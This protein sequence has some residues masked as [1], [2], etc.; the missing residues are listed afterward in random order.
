MLKKKGFT[1]IELLVVISIIAL[2]LSILMPA[3]NAV[4]ERTRFV[5][6]K[7]N[8]RQLSVAASAYAGDNNDKL[9]HP[10]YFLHS[11]DSYQ[12][13]YDS[14]TPL[15]CIWHDDNL[16]MDSVLWAYL[17][18]RDVVRCPTFAVVCNREIHPNHDPSIPIKPKFGYVM[19][20]YVLKRWPIDVPAGLDPTL[21]EGWFTYKLSEINR[22][23]EVLLLGEENPFIIAENLNDPDREPLSN[24]YLSETFFMPLPVGH[25]DWP[26]DCIATF[27]INRN[28]K[29][30]VSNVCFADG[31][32]SD[33]DGTVPGTSYKL[34][35]RY[36][37]R[38]T[39]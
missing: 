29:R 30:G 13:A 2:L 24:T 26:G 23:S 27:H 7:S 37:D 11:E 5:V 8:L 9:M 10:T 39:K 31:H 16:Q 14:G 35:G 18:D 36:I 1:L 21:P 32:V 17:D 25:P 3:L 4:K 20:A 19:N 22:P 15:W 33:E 38:L 28:I 6:C 34:T 12:R